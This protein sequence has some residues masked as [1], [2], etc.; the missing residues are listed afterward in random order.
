MAQQLI[1]TARG[2][3]QPRRAHGRILQPVF[4]ACRFLSQAALINF[5]VLVTSLAIVTTL[6]ALVAG[7]SSL[8]ALLKEGDDRVVSN[9]L[10][11]LRQDF[12][13]RVC[14]GVLLLFLLALVAGNLHFLH[15]Q[16]TAV[17]LPFY[18]LNVLLAL[19]WLTGA[20][21]AV[22]ICAGGASSLRSCLA[23]ALRDSVQLSATNAIVVLAVVASGALTVLSPVAAVFYAAVLPLAAITLASQCFSSHHTQG[24]SLA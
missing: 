24:E 10:R 16:A 7:Y 21:A 23:V 22:R 3:R 13:R 1:T 8:E 9:F 19:F 15:H 6:P 18:T 2:P 12:L 4:A 17:A 5:L 14:L 11:S 20:A